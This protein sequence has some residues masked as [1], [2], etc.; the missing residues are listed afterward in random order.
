MREGHIDSL[1][2]YA[3]TLC[4]LK[5]LGCCAGTQ[6]KN[7]ITVEEITE[8]RKYVTSVKDL[9]ITGGE[10]TLHKYF[11]EIMDEIF[12]MKYERIILATNGYG[13]MKHFDMLDNFD[14]IRISHYT[15]E[16]YPN[17]TPN[18]ESIKEFQKKYK[19][20]ARVVV[21]PITMIA[22]NDKKGVCGRAFNG[23]ASYFRGKIYGCCVSAGMDSAKGIKID[24]NWKESALKVELPCA[25]CVFAL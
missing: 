4:N 14:E 22:D 25:D 24:K 7:N 18:T 11:K 3:T 6:A 19:G 8:L 1:S 15:K 13:L 5:C 23:I 17:A 10:P 9:F 16:S 21:Q 12:K 2:I 20:T